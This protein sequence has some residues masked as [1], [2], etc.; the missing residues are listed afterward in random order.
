LEEDF[1]MANWILDSVVEV[2]ETG[3]E[4]EYPIHVDSKPNPCHIFVENVITDISRLPERDNDS[5]YVMQVSIDELRAILARRL[6][7]LIHPAT[8]DSV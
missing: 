7:D 5:K 3:K 6:W 4:T 2:D 1:E 8:T